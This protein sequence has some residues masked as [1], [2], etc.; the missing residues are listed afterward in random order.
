[1]IQ[2]HF[3]RW[4]YGTLLLLCTPPR[5]ATAPLQ[6]VADGEATRLDAGRCLAFLHCQK[7]PPKKMP[8]DLPK[9]LEVSVEGLYRVLKFP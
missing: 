8:R 9:E 5:P 1:M 4:L 2:I 6:F 7:V 3:R